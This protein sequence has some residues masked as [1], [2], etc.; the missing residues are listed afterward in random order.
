KVTDPAGRVTYTL[1][2][3]AEHEVRSFAWDAPNNKLAGPGSVSIEKR[4]ARYTD[5][6]TIAT[7]PLFHRGG[8]P[9][10]SGYPVTVPLTSTRS[11][12]NKAGQSIETHAYFNLTGLNYSDPA[13]NDTIKSGSEVPVDVVVL[14]GAQVNANFYASTADYDSR[15]RLKR[16]VS[17]TGTV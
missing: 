1:Y 6:L 13:G 16:S 15:G 5:A 11:L 14:H 7:P 4:G 10:W 9:S 12:L 3:D 2:P 17:P 8:L